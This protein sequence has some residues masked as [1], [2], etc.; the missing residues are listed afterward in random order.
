[1]RVAIATPLLYN[2]LTRLS[3]EKTKGA[4]QAKRRPL[5]DS[6]LDCISGRRLS[7]SSNYHITMN[8]TGWR[9]SGRLY[10]TRRAATVNPKR[11]RPRLGCLPTFAGIAS[12][13]ATFATSTRSSPVLLAPLASCY[14]DKSLSRCVLAPNT[15]LPT[16]PT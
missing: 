9:H 15:N 16:L 14:F 7:H 4:T 5:V 6:I 10:F 1:M 8:E 2:D 11:Q 3:I 12:T 13:F